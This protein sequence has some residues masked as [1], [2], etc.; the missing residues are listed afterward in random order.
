VVSNFWPSTA[1][2]GVALSALRHAKLLSKDGHCVSII[3]SDSK[4]KQEMLSV[5]RYCISAKGGGSLYSPARIDRRGIDEL[6]AHIKPDLVITEGWQTA[7]TDGFIDAAFDLNIRILVISHGVSLHPFSLRLL[8]LFRSV[9][10]FLYRKFSLP[11]RLTKISSLTCVDM[12][13]LSPRFYDRDLANNFGLN[14]RLLPNSPVNFSSKIIN[15]R[16]RVLTIVLVGYFSRIKNQLAAINLMKT[17]P[18]ELSLHLIGRK[19]GHYYDKCR[20][21]VTKLNLDMRIKFIDDSEC[22]VG[23]EIGS[24]LVVL[25]T[26][27][28]EVQPL[29][30]LE[31]MASGT[32][33]VATPVGG[34]VNLSGGILAARYNAQIEAI[35]SIYEDQGLWE[36]LSDEGLGAIKSTYSDEITTNEFSRIINDLLS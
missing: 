33:F 2:N 6:L 28:T 32:P 9:S 12:V 20:S 8:E 13:S 27:I 14:V 25:S 29:V 3:G 21:L 10:W 34:V 31:A 26:S 23:A 36:R 30:L 5:D 22:L 16:S 1:A 4:V 35:L 17:L 7:L 19:S 24:A 18:A 11:R 15:R